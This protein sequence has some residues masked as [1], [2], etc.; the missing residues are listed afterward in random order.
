MATTG[1]DP[2][3]RWFTYGRQIVVGCQLVAQ[4]GLLA[5]CLILQWTFHMAKLGFL[6]DGGQVPRVTYQ[7]RAFQEDKLQ[8]VA[9]INPLFNVSLAKASYMAKQD[10]V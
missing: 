1:R 7:E 10:S 4:L 5:K 9:F 8:C 2:L 3:P 6:Q